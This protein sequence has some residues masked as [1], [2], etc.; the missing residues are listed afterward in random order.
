MLARCAKMDETS[1]RVLH[2]RTPFLLLDVGRKTPFSRVGNK[3]ERDSAV[4]KTQ[5]TYSA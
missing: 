1:S 4:I 3:G 2:S 5:V